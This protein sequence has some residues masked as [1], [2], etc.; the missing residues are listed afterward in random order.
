MS[1][2]QIAAR[3]AE[4]LQKGRRELLAKLKSQ[5]KKVDYFERAKRLEE[6]PLLQESMHLRQLQDESFWEQQE[7]ERIAALLEERRLAVATKERLMRMKTDKD[8]F[9]EKLLKERNIVYE[10]KLREF[11]KMLAEER[12]RLLAERKALRKEERRQRY[13]KMKEEEEERKRL[14]QQ[15]REEEERTRLE[16]IARKEREEQ[17]RQQREEEEKKKKEHAEMLERSQAKQRQRELE[18]EKRMAE[19]K[20]KERE[21]P[22]SWRRLKE[23]RGENSEPWRYSGQCKFLFSV[24]TINHIAYY[25]Q[26]ILANKNVALPILKRSRGAKVANAAAG[27]LEV[28]A[29][30]TAIEG[31]IVI[32]TGIASVTASPTK[33]ETETATATASRTEIG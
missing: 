15:R 14:E 20:G 11:E 29:V 7:K 2:D 18:M 1:A 17:E 32:V 27:I 28:A 22:S 30:L 13:L 33:T 23:S 10:D 26:R 4:E 19:D 25:L 6:I 31:M 16:E 24:V 3:E 21:T 9:L 5:E 12:T 8:A